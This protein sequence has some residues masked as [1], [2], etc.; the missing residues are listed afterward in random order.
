MRGDAS[1][2]ESADWSCAFLA[3]SCVRSS[4][5]LSTLRLSCSTA[6]LTNTTPASRTA[7]TAIQ[8]I[9]PR[10]RARR[11]AR[12]LGGGRANRPPRGRAQDRLGAAR[13]DGEI[14]RARAPVL[15]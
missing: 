5:A 2:A 9:A 3:R 4:V 7:L 11:V 6:R 1:A 8:R 13:T 12:D 14:G 15:L 10:E